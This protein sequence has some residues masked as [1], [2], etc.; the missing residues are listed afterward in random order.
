MT[1]C[2]QIEPLLTGFVDGELV[3]QEMQAVARHLAA[4]QKCESELVEFSAIGERLREVGGEF[5]LEGFT[6]SVMAK[7]PRPTPIRDRLR[8]FLDLFDERLIAGTALGAAT[9][10]IG[11]WTMILVTPMARDLMARARADKSAVIASASAKAEVLGVDNATRMAAVAHRSQ[12]V[13]SRLE[14]QLPN[15]AVWSEPDTEATVIWV[16]DQR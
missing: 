2:E 8:G 9:L 6:Q 1:Q 10:A 13:I 7:L 15:V 16:P 4:C 11:A 5:Q 12:A 3:P 14:S